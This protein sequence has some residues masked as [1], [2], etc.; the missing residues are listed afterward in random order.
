MDIMDIL[1]HLCNLAAG[2]AIIILFT[3]IDNKYAVG[4]MVISESIKII[5]SLYFGN[6]YSILASIFFIVVFV[7]GYKY[8]PD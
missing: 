8:F 1:L 5:H 3:K 2:L 6:V 7:L 4:L